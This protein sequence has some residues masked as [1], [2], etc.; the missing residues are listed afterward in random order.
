MENLLTTLGIKQRLITKTKSIIALPV[1]AAIKQPYGVVHGGI[2]GVLAETAASL[3]ANANL[4]AD[5]VAVG[6]N[7]TVQ[8][9]QAV[10]QG[11]LIAT[12]TPLHIGHHLQTWQVAITVADQLTSQATVTL[13]TIKK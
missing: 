13:T 2:N 4:D 12:A 9:L 5:R 1:S 3:G 8:H 11:E 6:V 10:T 7:L